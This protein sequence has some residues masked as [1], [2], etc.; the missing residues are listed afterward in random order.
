MRDK[1]SPLPRTLS[2][3]HKIKDKISGKPKNLEQLLNLIRHAQH[4]AVIDA[5]SLRMIEGVI[6][7]SD[8]PAS[9]IMIS[10]AEMVVVQKDMS[11]NEILEIV[12]E[13]AHSRIPVIGDNKD[14]V[15]G[16][17][18]A[19]D[20]LPHAINAPSRRFSI[21]DILR[22]CLFIPESKRLGILLNAFR[23]DRN[24]LAIVVDEFGGV[25]G[26]VTIED[27]IEQIVGEIEDEHD[28]EEGIYIRLHKDKHYSVKALTPIDEFNKFFGTNL[29]DEEFD[30]IGGLVLKGF[31]HLP[32]R[33]ESLTI[34]EIPFTVLRATNRR[35][36]LLKTTLSPKKKSEG[37]DNLD[38]GNE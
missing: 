38:S 34:E 26:I 18:L 12:I 24:H 33:G 14:E 28:V 16:I 8:M 9:E 7:I 2:W 36:Q 10:R 32:K 37:E 27:V 11:L 23:K 1:D 22:S 15:I 20:L 31:G 35:I 13:S 25:S 6:Q 21:K 3:F 5:E 4:D 19:K 17:L 30:T 29:S